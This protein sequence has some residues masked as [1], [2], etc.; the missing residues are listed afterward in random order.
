MP[1]SGTLKA[2][3]G[4][5][6]HPWLWLSEWGYQ[7]G[8]LVFIRERSIDLLRVT[9]RGRGLTRAVEHHNL[10]EIS[11]KSCSST[12]QGIRA[13]EPGCASEGTVSWIIVPLTVNEYA[14]EDE[15]E[16]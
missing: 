10:G 9:S 3:F 4:Q 14:A 12:V 13:Q 5:L 2:Q 1:P 8:Y 16:A 7:Y 11:H 6:G 15:G